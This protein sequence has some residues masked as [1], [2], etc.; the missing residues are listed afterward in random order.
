MSVE[1]FL[2][3]LLINRLQD[4]AELMGNDIERTH[5]WKT[6]DDV[7]SLSGKPVRLKFVLR[8]ADLFSFRFQ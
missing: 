7:S 1:L 4:A 3:A 2:D 6:T 8:D 5:R